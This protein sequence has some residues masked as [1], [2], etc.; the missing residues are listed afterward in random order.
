MEDLR[1]DVERYAR[2]DI[3]PCQGSLWHPSGSQGPCDILEHPSGITLASVCRAM[4]RLLTGGRF[5]SS[6]FWQMVACDGRC[7]GRLRLL[8]AA[9]AA[10]AAIVPADDWWRLEYI[11]WAVAAMGA[12]KANRDPGTPPAPPPPKAQTAD[13][14]PKTKAPRR[15]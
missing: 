4:P 3:M 6:F 10:A 14:A 2:T 12:M 13:P 8:Q 11:P 9:A 7:D 1:A 5:C 15:C